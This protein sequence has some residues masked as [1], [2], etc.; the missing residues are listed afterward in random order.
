MPQR[1]GRRRRDVAP[2]ETVSADPAILTAAAEQTVADWVRRGRGD[3]ASTRAAFVARFGDDPD[4]MPIP[5]SAR[6][7]GDA[8]VRARRARLLEQYP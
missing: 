4:A 5:E 3:W 6:V 7:L 8:F 2:T 1:K